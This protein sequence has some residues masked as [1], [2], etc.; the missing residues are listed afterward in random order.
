MV[1]IGGLCL[2]RKGR[3]VFIDYLKVLGL[4]LVILAHFNAPE[5]IMQ[6]RSFDVP[7][8][9]FI[10]GYLARKS[11]KKGNV[12]QYYKKRIIRLIIPA[13]IFLVIFFGAQKIF[14]IS[15]SLEEIIKGFL[16]QKDAQMVGM[17][18]VIWV[19]FIC[20]LL[21]PLF[22]KVEISSKKMV[23]SLVIMIAFEILC[24]CTNIENSRI[25]YMTVLTAI[26]WGYV[27]FLGFNYDK[28]E[29]K[30]KIYIE[31]IL[32]I[33]FLA[34]AIY[35]VINNNSFITTSN[36]KYPARIYYLSYALFWVI[37]LFEC[38]KKIKLKENKYIEFLSKSSLWIYLW[39]ILLMYAIKLIITS[40]KL[41]ML[42]YILVLASSIIITAIQNEMVN[43]IMKKHNIKILK[44]FLG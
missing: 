43:A 38:F 22:D 29:K 3:I 12:K 37:I 1:D 27:T 33:I 19:Y 25:L 5:F 42:Q 28:L 14:Y 36:Y 4:F 21:I 24:V 44:V 34:F 11:Y 35:F 13:W 31:I 2:K 8:L 32:L 15:P 39:H 26:P 23:W 40:D 17:I 16:F 30:H 6:L 9:V 7:L 20:S 18:W 10:S 41:W